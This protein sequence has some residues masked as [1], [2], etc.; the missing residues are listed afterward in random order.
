M[1]FTPATIAAVRGI[2]PAPAAS[3]LPAGLPA[4]MLRDVVTT[5]LSARP[6]VDADHA[7]RESGRFPELTRERGSSWRLVPLDPGLLPLSFPRHL[8]DCVA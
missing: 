4:E 5:A 3:A 7:D 1:R 8:A 2:E 6:D